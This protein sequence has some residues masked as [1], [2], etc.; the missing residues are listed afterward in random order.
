MNNT[1][2]D[3][4]TLGAGAILLTT[5]LFVCMSLGLT[6]LIFW[7][8]LGP[9]ALTLGLLWAALPAVL[10]KRHLDRRIASLRGPGTAHRQS[11]PD[12]W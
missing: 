7:I 1:T 9:W 11:R 2:R 8:G 5:W 12:R 10:Y 3:A 4:I 6:V